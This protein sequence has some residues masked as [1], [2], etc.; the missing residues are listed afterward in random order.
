MDGFKTEEEQVE[1]LKK[2]WEE[3]GKSTVAAVVIGVVGYFGFNAYQ[4]HQDQRVG[5]AT[6][7][8]GQ[9]LQALQAQGDDSIVT[10]KTLA[11]QVVADYSDLAVANQAKLALAKI[12]VEEGDLDQAAT[13]LSEVSASE[14]EFA[15]IA[16]YR[17]AVVKNMQGDVDGALAA[18]PADQAG[19]ESLFQELRGDLLAKKGDTAGAIAEYEKVI[20][21]EGDVAYARR[22]LIKMKLNQL[23]GT[24]S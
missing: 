1:A 13:Q 5:T 4:D 11:N 10:A 12:A 23:M 8:Q 15:L 2:W 14:G 22:E 3:N 7:L 9:V 19:F 6:A 17:L 24:E 20:G 16:S 21:A 18:L